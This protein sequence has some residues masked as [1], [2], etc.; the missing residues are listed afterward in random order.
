M[1]SEHM[2]PLKEWIEGH[3]DCKTWRMF[4]SYNMDAHGEEV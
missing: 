2:R 1:M 4:D 3:F